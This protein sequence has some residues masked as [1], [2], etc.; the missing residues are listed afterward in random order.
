VV[1]N[2]GTASV[3]AGTPVTKATM[4]TVITLTADSAPTG[5]MF[6]AWI[7]DGAVVANANSAITTFTMPAGN[8]TATATYKNIPVQFADVEEGAYY[9]DAMLWAVENGITNGTSPTT[10]SPNNV[11]TRAEVVTFLWRA[12]G[13]P[14]ATGENQFSDVQETDWYY[15]AVLW[16]VS[17]GITTGT[18]DGKFSPTVVCDRSQVVTFLYRFA[19]S[20]D[21]AEGTENPFTDVAEDAWYAKAVLWAVGEQITNGTGAGTFTPTRD[22]TRGEIVTFLYR[23]V[24][25]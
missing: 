3:D 21:L 9:Y 15:Q 19:D 20:P 2:G 7:V 23:A 16:A 13:K 14:Q 4:G 8:V 1:V 5:M 10:F 11:C 17:E 22:C 18:G 25:R 6:D 12:A 24:G